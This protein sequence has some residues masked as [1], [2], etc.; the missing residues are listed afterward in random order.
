MYGAV[1]LLISTLLLVG[2]GTNPYLCALGILLFNSVM[3]VTLYEVYCIFPGA[4]GFS[5]GLT[6]VLLFLGFLP[7]CFFFPD[8]ELKRTLLLILCMIAAACL[9]AAAF[10]NRAKEKR[11]A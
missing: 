11:K 8:E 7:S 9:M 10:L 1:A 4:P 5:L 6:T 3:P 2:L